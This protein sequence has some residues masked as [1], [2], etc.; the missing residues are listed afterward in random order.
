M[1][2]VRLILDFDQRQV[3]D[4]SS[5]SIVYLQGQLTL[6]KLYN[7]LKAKFDIDPE[8]VNVFDMGVPQLMCSSW[9]LAQISKA[10][11]NHCFNLPSFCGKTLSYSLSILWYLRPA[12]APPPKYTNKL[13]VRGNHTYHC[14]TTL[15]ITQTVLIQLYFD[16]WQVKFNIDVGSMKQLYY[17]SKHHLMP[18]LLTF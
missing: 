3:F 2:K 1:I 17:V 6:I 9:Y 7:Q 14:A 18:L 5:T 16:T 13:I 10:L 11:I 8:S 4:Q 15:K 12:C